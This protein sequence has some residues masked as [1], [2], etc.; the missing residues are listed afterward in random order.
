MGRERWRVLMILVLGAPVCFVT[1]LVVLISATLPN[2]IL[3]ITS[4]FMT[5]PVRILIKRDELTLEGIKQFFVAVEREEWKFDTLCDL[6]DALMIAQAVV[7]CNTKRK[8]DWL[9][10][11]LR[12]N[13]F[14]ASC[15]HGDMPQR[16]R[17]ATMGEFRSGQTRVLITTDVWA[18]GIDVQQV[19]LVI[20]YD[21]PNNRELY[22]HRIGRTGCFGR[23]P[24]RGKLLFGPPGTGKSLLAKA[25]A[26]EIKA[27]FIIV[28]AASITFKW[29][30]KTSNALFSY[31]KKLAPVVIYLDEVD[32]LLGARGENETSILK[33]FV[34]AWD[35][36]E[37]KES[38]RVLVIGGTNRPFDIDEAVI[39]RMPR[40]I[41]V[42]LPDVDILVKMP[43]Y[44]GGPVR[45]KYYSQ[46]QYDEVLDDWS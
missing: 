19:Y 18:G 7:F 2:E 10:G 25:I 24:C 42:G 33:G 31:A 26:T 20:N 37:L 36:L 28:S 14:A 35:G 17:D 43:Q 41:Y 11:K 4:K 27:N 39:C 16:E 45:D 8:V 29:L 1:G 5:D 15:M 40:R 9:T 13:N 34:A 21:L 6:Y 3:E 38:Q 30:E 12:E 46:A 32:S 23:K 22:I 44:G